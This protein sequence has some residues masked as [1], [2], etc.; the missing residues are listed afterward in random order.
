MIRKTHKLHTSKAIGLILEQLKSYS[1]F[2]NTMAML[3][4][5]C[6]AFFLSNNAYAKDLGVRGQ[7]YKIVEEDPVTHIERKL[8]TM[9]ENGELAEHKQIL[10]ART[11]EKLF[12][13]TRVKGISKATEDRVFYHDPTITLKEDIKD[14]EGNII[15]KAGKTINPLDTVPMRIGLLFIDGDDKEQ[16]KFALSQDKKLPGGFNITLINGSP[17]ALEKEYNIPIYFDQMGILS[18]K[19]GITKV[20]LIVSQEGNKIKIQEIKLEGNQWN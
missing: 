9:E 4:S 1:V 18:Q 7:T 19:F 6:C 20:P 17:I 15:H 5:L 10:R 13:P 8:N 11:K 14:H 3:T 2:V 12:R 16:I